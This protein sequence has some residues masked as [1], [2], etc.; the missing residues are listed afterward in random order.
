M[1][2][3]YQKVD[4]RSRKAMTDFLQNHFRYDTMNGWN[5]STSYANNLKV[6]EIG[7]SFEQEM[8]LLNI[9]GCDG[10]YD[11]INDLI[12]QFGNDHD[13][14][15]QAGF[16]GRSGGYLVLYRGGTRQSEYKSYCISC[17]QRN[18]TSVKETGCKC[19]K[20]GRESRKDYEKPP[21]EILTY[22]GKDVD[23]SEDLE[24]WS[25]KD[26]RE[27]V[28]LVE[29]FDKLCDEIISKAAYMADNY[30]VA[31]EEVEVTEIHRV[32]RAIGG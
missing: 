22:P 12:W 25:M 19:G 1:K 2:Q 9:I 24:D 29:E 13:W 4:R 30:E 3:C 7:L 16:N 28:Q 31:E 11:S 10:A 20:C 8:K 14:K 6:H 26:L 15:W 32:L 5:K 18:Y 21:I 27:R 23:M 17:G